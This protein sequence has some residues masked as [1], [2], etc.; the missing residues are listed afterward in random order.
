[1]QRCQQH[2]AY[3]MDT[4]PLSASSLKPIFVYSSHQNEDDIESHWHQSPVVLSV[5][6]C[7][8]S[9]VFWHHPFPR[10]RACTHTQRSLG[11]RD[12]WRLTFENKPWVGSHDRG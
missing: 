12:T 9:L 11:V 7:R 10:A 2:V 8:S 6:P 5:G 1:M 4:Q 3:S